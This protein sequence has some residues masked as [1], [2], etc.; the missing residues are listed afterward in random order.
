M[1]G[2]LA[3]CEG[4]LGCSG[5]VLVSWA[6]SEELTECSGMFLKHFGNALNVFLQF[7]VVFCAVLAVLWC[8]PGLIEYFLWVF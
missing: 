6:C 7:L 2:V 4:S 1:W 8:V 3:C 5:S